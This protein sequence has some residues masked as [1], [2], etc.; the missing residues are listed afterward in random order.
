MTDLTHYLH[1]PE[2]HGYT[3]AYTAM[4]LYSKTNMSTLC[5]ITSEP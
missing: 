2:E 1:H 5:V 4:R 3:L